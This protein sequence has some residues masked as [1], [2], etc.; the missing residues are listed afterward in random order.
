M[1]EKVMLRRLKF[2][3]LAGP[4]LVTL[5]GVAQAQTYP[6]R[7]ITWVVPT[8]AGGA[9]DISVRVVAKVLSE[10]LN[11]PV[12]IENRSGAGGVLGTA[13]VANAKPDGYT[14]LL[15]GTGPFTISPNI[16][17]TLQYDPVK[18][19]IMIHTLWDSPAILLV[20]VNSPYKSISELLSY[21]KANPGTIKVG[22][23]GIGT[24]THL[25]S[26]MLQQNAQ[27]KFTIVPYKGNAAALTD[28]LAGNLDLMLDFV[29]ASGTRALALTGNERVKDLPDVPTL[30]EAG[31]PNSVLTGWTMVAV[32]A[33][34]PQTIVDQLSKAFDEAFKKPEVVAYMKTNNLKPMEPMTVDVLHQFVIKENIKVKE[35]VQKAGIE[36]Q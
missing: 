20:G 30:R 36:P 1:M 35:L 13:H 16:S 8:G 19:F 27:I 31:V 3:V 7:P 14:L 18:S 24:T 9:V 15:A 6:S 11:T 32:P 2:L 25:I 10:I 21:A 28:V 33:G 22:H 26:E 12:V 5:S 23:A 17:K 4:L 34:T 29:V